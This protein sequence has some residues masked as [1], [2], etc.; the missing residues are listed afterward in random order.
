MGLMA[1]PHLVATF[2]NNLQ[3]VRGQWGVLPG[4]DG[5]GDLASLGRDAVILPEDSPVP[6]RHLIQ[7]LL[8][9]VPIIPALLGLLFTQLAQACSGKQKNHTWWSQK[10][11]WQWL[12]MA[13]TTGWTGC[14]SLQGVF[15][16]LLWQDIHRKS[17]LLLTMIV[18]N[19]WELT[20]RIFSTLTFF[21]K[22]ASFQA[23]SLWRCLVW[24]AT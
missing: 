7:F 5:V 18:S 17:S 23:L 8:R 19:K 15:S 10:S 2:V 3:D 11:Q 1:W 14:K 13:K 21:S 12:P 24:I 16:V 4:T 9:P 22:A 20:S 6:V